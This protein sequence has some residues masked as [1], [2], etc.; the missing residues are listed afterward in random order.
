MFI[1]CFQLGNR[2]TIARLT[3]W[4]QWLTDRW[5]QPLIDLLVDPPAI[6]RTE[7]VTDGLTPQRSA[8]S[9]WHL[10]THRPAQPQIAG[11]NERRGFSCAFN[12]GRAS[13]VHRWDGAAAAASV[14]KSK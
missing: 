11:G 2:S 13:C 5:I 1:S 8:A 3:A 7:R 4:N 9:D 12:N 14:I 10:H 6:H